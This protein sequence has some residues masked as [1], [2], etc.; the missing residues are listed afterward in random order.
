MPHINIRPAPDCAI[1][2]VK[3]PTAAAVK[4]ALK[5]QASAI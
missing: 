5:Q 1:P 4:D 3:Y 2:R